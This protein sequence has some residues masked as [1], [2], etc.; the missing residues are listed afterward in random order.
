ME[1][2][3][4]AAPCYNTFIHDLFLEGAHWGSKTN[5]FNE[6]FLLKLYPQPPVVSVKVVYIDNSAA[7]HFYSDMQQRLNCNFVGYQAGKY[8]GSYYKRKLR[9]TKLLIFK[10]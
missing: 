2:E 1:N 7:M 5:S 10:H 3:V 6:T 8:G 4:D 9:D